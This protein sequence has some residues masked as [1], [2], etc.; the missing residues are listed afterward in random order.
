MFKVKVFCYFLCSIFLVCNAQKNEFIENI[1]EKLNAIKTND[2]YYIN[3]NMFF[4]KNSNLSKL[5]T[6]VSDINYIS[7]Y[8]FTFNDTVD[9]P[10][11][12][13]S[14]VYNISAVNNL[15]NLFY[16]TSD[17][18][19]SHSLIFKINEEVNLKISSSNDTENELDHDFEADFLLEKHIKQSKFVF[20]PTI[21]LVYLHSY[22]SL[23]IS[24]KKAAF[25]NI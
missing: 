23:S 17:V 10:S 15:T 2:V 12:N 22:L 5:I 14:A 13:I 11:E 3:E 19:R 4:I 25:S 7:D 24:I 8:N 6:N 18:F 16:I 1:V 20:P 9:K 21:L